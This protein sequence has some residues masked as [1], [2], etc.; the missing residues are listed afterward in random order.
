MNASGLA[1]GLFGN[2]VKVYT[3]PLSR[4]DGPSTVRL[5]DLDGPQPVRVRIVGLVL[6]DHSS[7]KPIIVGRI[8]SR[9]R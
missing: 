7:N 8:V 5:T 9:L 2:P 3:S 1:G 6:L 4:F